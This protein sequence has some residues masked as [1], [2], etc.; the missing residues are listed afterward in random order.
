MT[1]HNF[2]LLNHG[3][4]PLPED[5]RNTSLKPVASLQ[6]QLPGNQRRKVVL[7][8]QGVIPEVLAPHGCS[9]AFQGETYIRHADI[10]APV[11]Q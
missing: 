1:R 9:Q 4:A 11:A 3:L 8:H 10:P 7:M 5:L 6:A 2:E